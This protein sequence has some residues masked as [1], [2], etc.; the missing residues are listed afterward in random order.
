MKSH[1][2][3]VLASIG[4][5][6]EATGQPAMLPYRPVVADFSAALDRIITISGNP[7]TLHIYD[8]VS[9]KEA[10]VSLVQPPLSLSVS[11]DGKHAAVGHDALVSYVNLVTGAVD[12]TFTVATVVDSLVLS[13]QW[14]YVMSGRQGRGG[15]IN[16][17]SGTVSASN[18]S[19]SITG[20]RI[21]T[22]VNAIYGTRD[23]TSPNDIEK[24]DISTGPVTSQTD[25]VYH[26]DYCVFGPVWF[27]PDGARIY[28]GCG[29][30]FRASTD[31]KLD[32][33]Y[34]TSMKGVSSI[35]SLSES[36]ALKRVA[37]LQGRPVYPANTIN[38]STVM[39]FD[40]TYLKP[41]GQFALPNVSAGGNSYQA[42]GRWLFFN[43]ASSELFVVVQADQTSGLLNDYGVLRIPLQQPTAC[44]AVFQSAA[45][46][47]AASGTS[48]SVK[49]S[50]AANCFYQ[51]S[52]TSSWIEVVSGGYASGDGTLSYIVRPNPNSSPRSGTI[53]LAGQ[54]FTINQD[55]AT[56]N[57][58]PMAMF[59]F[60]VIDAAYDKPLDKLILVSSGPDELHIYDPVSKSDR[61]VSLVMPPLSLSV[62]PDGIH[63]AVGHDGWASYINLESG[64]V[65]KVFQVVTDVRH[66]LLAGNGYMYLFPARDWSDIYALQVSSGAVTA[67]SAIYEGRV[68]RLYV[69]GNYLYVG[70]NWFSKWDIS[71]GVPKLVNTPTFGVSTCGNLW[72]TEDGRRVFTACGKVYTASEVPSQDLQ[73]N[74]TLSLASSLAWLDESAQQHL[75]V[76]IPGPRSSFSSSSG[77][78]QAD[79]TQLQIYKDEFLGYSGAIALPQFTVGGNSFAAHGRFVFWNKAASMLYAVVQADST[80]QLQGGWA[81]VAV[82]PSAARQLTVNSIVN[83]ASQVQARI[84]PGEIV[85]VYGSG[86]GPSPGVSFT[87]DSVSGK[88]STNLAGTQVFFNGV[89]A[90]VLYAADAQVNVIVPYEVSFGSGSEVTVQ[91]GYQSVLS[92]GTPLTTATAIPG[93]FTINGSGSGQAVAINQD[94]TV[95]D[96]AH[97]AAP[98]SFITVYF[99]GGGTLN[100]SGVTGSVTGT[101]L[102][103]LSQTALVTVG[104][105]PA[106]V[107]FA[108][109]A[110][111]F[112]DGVG[113][114]N[115]RLAD[116]TPSGSAQPLILTVG[117]N[118]SPNTATIAVR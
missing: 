41:I 36:A 6:Q 22:A 34:M 32:M 23:G 28:T 91:A 93:I 11:P 88:V 96:S 44:G 48:G 16:I 30:V 109:A 19:F 1:L 118:S 89:A 78:I 71:Q 105:Q 12:K 99:T 58:G 90:P 61:A 51:A 56:A 86:L 18:N 24:L 107:T 114:L 53:L 4:L 98:G 113:Q 67:T 117:N 79:D 42:H 103:R 38:D 27:S 47:A 85:T 40:S 64:V 92:A 50:A 17:A 83:T 2:L 49:I 26:G 116:N 112:V 37:L 70:G 31:P 20:G 14:I 69:N 57:S 13:D 81:V 52:T 65:E 3:V 15:S 75:S 115:I 108:G 59:G 60:S 102:K 80:S 74:G 45:A 100:P 9:Q 82:A 8:P 95:C 66:V 111:G 87:V 33:Y 21:N 77:P 54:I 25:S 62:A 110:P 73:Y 39:L 10:T 55:A 68:P 104:N 5:I 35:G 46:Q 94:G 72:L 7:N 101:Q 106:T 97:P 43:A 29:T 84:A 76:A 63:A